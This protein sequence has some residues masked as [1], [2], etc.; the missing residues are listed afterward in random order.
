MARGTFR[1]H[2]PS[3]PCILEYIKEFESLSAFSQFSKP[4]FK[5]GAPFAKPRDT[6]ERARQ[7]Q[8]SCARAIRGPAS[9][10]AMRSYHVCAHFVPEAARRVLS[11]NFSGFSSV[12]YA[13]LPHSSE[14]ACPLSRYSD[15][16]QWGVVEVVRDEHWRISGG[17]GDGE[18][19]VV[20]TVVRRESEPAAVASERASAR[21]HAPW[22]ST[23]AFS[24][25]TEAVVA[26]LIVFVL[27]PAFDAGLQPLFLTARRFFMGPADFFIFQPRLSHRIGTNSTG[28]V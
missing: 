4:N 18:L 1:T 3:A 27:P 15:V 21:L 5:C 28:K 6:C 13:S 19:G 26:K 7:R 2:T 17:G 22:A 10:R 20:N 8:Q 11:R 12:A 25:P 24:S 16:L 9:Q 23:A 14:D